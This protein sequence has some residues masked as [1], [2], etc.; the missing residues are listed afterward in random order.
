MPDPV[1]ALREAV[2]PPPAP[3]LI[4]E[5]R[6][7]LR[8]RRQARL[9]GLVA[10][11][12]AVVAAS[13]AVWSGVDPDRNDVLTAP[14]SNPA[15]SAYEAAPSPGSSPLSTGKPTLTGKDRIYSNE[16]DY[17]PGRNR[18]SAYVSRR[19]GV[20][21]GQYEDRST[22]VVVLGPQA[23]AEGVDR[24][25]DELQRIGGRTKLRVETCDV[26]ES[27]LLAIMAEIRDLPWPSGPRPTY[28][29]FP[30]P[31][32]CKVLLM[33][34]DLSEADLALVRERFGDRVR[35]EKGAVGRATKHPL[36]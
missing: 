29:A 20:F 2:R 3:D 15:S 8:R 10:G 19:P 36:P 11:T 35:Y 30:E 34:D 1:V 23:V 9:A 25:R 5:L 4:P 14:T 12:V 33:S 27:D 28:A 6:S 7:R 32:T 17:P 22:W 26:S 24:W 13:T 21:T 18:L 31:A 16:N